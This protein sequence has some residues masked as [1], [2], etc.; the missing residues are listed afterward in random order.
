MP[1]S[2]ELVAIERSRRLEGDAANLVDMRLDFEL[3]G[4]LLLS[5]GGLWNRRMSDWEG[6]VDA[7]E[8]RVV[9]RMH[10]GQRKATDWWRGW[11]SHH[12]G[13]RDSPPTV[14]EIEE[15]TSE[16][17]EFEVYSALM[18]GG[19]RSGKTFWAA[20]AVASY[21]VQ[22]DNAIAWAISPSRGRDDTKA[23]EIRRYM[24]ALLAPSW[25]RRQTVA[26]GWELINGSTIALK[27]AHV[28]ADP[29]AIKEGQADL[30][31]LNESQKM[32]KRVYVVARGAVADKG[33]IVLCCANPPVEAKDE[34]WV[35]D[36]A[37]ET[38]AG[39]RASVHIPFNPLDNPHIDRRALLS[40]SA[41][42][43]ERTFQIE[44]LGLFLPAVDCVAYNWLRKENEIPQPRPSRPAGGAQRECARTGLI[45]VTAEFLELEEEGESIEVLFGLD[46]QRIP[47][48]GGPAYRFF[49][50]PG[51]APT[52]DN[53]LAWIV[54]ECTLDGG[55]E[56]QW[57]AELRE[58]GYDPAHTLIVCDASGQWQHSRRRQADSPP[59]EWTGRGSFD[60]IRSAGFR[61]I[62]SPSRRSPK[63]NPEIQDRVRA[64][65]SM[66][67]SKVGTRRLF[68]DP[69]A[70]QKSCKAIREWKTINGK[71]S[72][73]QD[74]AHLGDG[75]SYP[76]IRLF[77]RI[78]RS[79]NTPGMD[80]VTQR[81]DRQTDAAGEFFG[82]PST[83]R[84]KVRR[85]YGL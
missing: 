14:E 78:L 6:D 28:G 26:T 75:I 8:S 9:V 68:C 62:V 40:L 23:D 69:E 43:D 65:T 61:R 1:R 45:D 73:I 49:A 74:V 27:S 58:D 71:P 38:D 3:N 80:P 53:V 16:I 18:A 24:V 82:G 36:F 21:D 57:C 85:N 2:N 55:D 63:K 11:L 37:A 84:G 39:R 42:V 70:A 50:P 83:R 54:G 19:R 31:W 12:A 5:A 34:Q 66:I 72:R 35:S 41:E 60:I 47:Y 33:G 10:P 44:V 25:I 64:F 67:C 22:F 30:V 79:G 56:E 17:D 77:P 81:V 59:P 7:C 20:A 13:R 52:R 48:I 4:T 32:K 51:L 46:V 29:D 76:L 15:D